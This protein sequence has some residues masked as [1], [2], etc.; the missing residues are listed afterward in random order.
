MAALQR[1]RPR[2]LYKVAAAVVALGAVGGGLFYYL[3]T[4]PLTASPVEDFPEVYSN[5]SVPDVY[6][7]ALREGRQRLLQRTVHFAVDREELE[8]DSLQLDRCLRGVVNA[9]YPDSL[10]RQG[11]AYRQAM[12]LVEKDVADLVA[13]VRGR[14]R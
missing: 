6:Q 9:H 8:A 13:D 12:R 7:Q 5:I 2:G 4:D 11:A 10:Q 1:T 3:A 14:L